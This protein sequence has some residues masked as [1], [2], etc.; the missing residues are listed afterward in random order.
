MA[1][2]AGRISILQVSFDAGATFTTIGK[3]VDISMTMNTSE[4]EFTNHDSAG[5]REYLPSFIDGTVEGSARD[6]E[7]NAVQMGILDSADRTPATTYS[8]WPNVQIR[9]VMETSA[10]SPA[11]VSGADEYKFNAF[12]TTFTLDSANEDVDQ[13][14]FSF[15][16]T[17]Q[18]VAYRDT[19]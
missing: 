2:L 10:A 9:V 4:I 15:R 3:L 5:Y 12:C 7:A 16:I 13:V 1:V 19:I 8:A 17:G 6:D 14:N 11:G 18:P